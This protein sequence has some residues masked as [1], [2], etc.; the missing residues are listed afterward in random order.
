MKIL[1]LGST[2]VMGSAIKK[3]CMERDI[4]HIGLSHTDLEVTNPLDMENAVSAHNPD[5]VINCVVFMGINPCE[6]NPDKAYAVN[7]TAVLNL[8]KICARKDIILVQ[9]SSHAVFD[10][11]KDDYYTEDDP[12]IITGTYSGSKYLSERFAADMCPR[13]YITRF[14]TIFGKRRNS[15]PGFVDKVTER[16]M[17]GLPLRIADDKIDSPTYS[18]DAAE[19]V[20]YLLMN[21]NECGVYHIANYGKVSYYDFVTK[22]K[23]ALGADAQIDRAKDADFPALGYKPL[24]TA[25]KSIKLPP[26][27]TWQDA[28]EEYIQEID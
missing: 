10:G 7:A 13:H 20:L 27:R 28:L 1:T 25:M 17:K 11:T 9:P 4:E 23:E 6:E 2:G 21:E 8:A 14:P 12:P 15:V 19:A 24:K 18:A 3:A 22:L 26:L 16:M 5:A